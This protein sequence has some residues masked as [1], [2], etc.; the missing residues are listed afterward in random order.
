MCLLL[1]LCEPFFPVVD[2]AALPILIVILSIPSMLDWS[3]ITV[4]ILPGLHVLCCMSPWIGSVIYHVFMNNRKGA[5]VYN[6]LL[7]FDI[8]G[9]WVSQAMGKFRLLLGF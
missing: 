9:I 2:L 4:Q 7:S 5:G 1:V 3:A 6:F 8:F